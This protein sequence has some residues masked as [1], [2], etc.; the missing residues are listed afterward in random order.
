MM[1]PIAPAQ[2]EKRLSGG[3]S[4]PGILHLV[5]AMDI[6]SRR[7]SATRRG[8]PKQEQPQAEYGLAS[9]DYRH[10]FVVS[11]GYELPFGTGK[12][13]FPRHLRSQRAVG[14]AADE[15]HHDGA[16]GRHLRYLCPETRPAWGN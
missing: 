2:A 5:K 9:M 15:W 4:F 11:Y 14:R 16:M 10:R 6:N 1:H 12:P 7:S 13:S 3:F 8:S